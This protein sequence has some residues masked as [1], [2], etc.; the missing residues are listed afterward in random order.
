[1]IFKTR[2]FFFTTLIVIFILS[3]STPVNSFKPIFSKG[4]QLKCREEGQ[5]VVI[6]FLK[7]DPCITCLCQ[8]STI[9]CFKDACPQGHNCYYQQTNSSSYCCS[10]CK[11]CSFNGKYLANGETAQD[12]GDL[13]LSYQCNSGVM[14]T[15]RSQCF[16]PCSNAVSLRGQCC[17][18][19][20][21]CPWWNAK[22]GQEVVTAAAKKDP[23]IRCHCFKGQLICMRQVCPVLPCP[24]SNWMQPLHSCCPVCKG[25]KDAQKLLLP[26][27][28]S[29]L[30]ADKTYRHEDAFQY[31]ECT[32]CVCQNGTSICHRQTCSCPLEE[33]GKQKT[34]TAD[35]GQQCCESCA[36]ASS[37]SIVK[38]MQTSTISNCHYKS[39]VYKESQQWTN[40]DTCEHCTCLGGKV[41]CSSLAAATARLC[42]HQPLICPPGYQR[43]KQKGQCCESCLMLG[44]SCHLRM[45]P[46]HPLQKSISTFDGVRFHFAGQ[47]NYVLMKDCSSKQF[48]VHLLNRYRRA[49]NGSNFEG[50]SVMVKI[51]STKIHLGHMGVVR[52]NHSKVTLPYIELGHFTIA[53]FDNR[54]KVRVS[55]ME[56]E[57]LF[58]FN[59]SVEIK[60]KNSHQGRLCGLCGNFNNNLDDE[61]QLKNTRRIATLEKFARSFQVG[62][63]LVCPKRRVFVVKSLPQKE[64]HHHHHH[65]QQQQHQKG[66]NSGEERPSAEAVAISRRICD[67]IRKR[68]PQCRRGHP[69]HQLSSS[70]GNSVAFEQCLTSMTACAG[71]QFCECRALEHFIGRCSGRWH[72]ALRGTMCTKSTAPTEVTINSCPPGSEWKACTSG[73]CRKT[74]RSGRSSSEQCHQQRRTAECRPGCQCIGNRVWHQQQCIPEVMCPADS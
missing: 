25:K 49:A 46:H 19:C 17:P 11:G 70:A 29:C 63:N 64:E 31:D 35:G 23:C 67:R 68:N 10:K 55:K 16:V 48:A 27:G 71:D 53:R 44:G 15:H 5:V 54:I 52:V 21:I 12:D 14:T 59:A 43:V 13:C 42:P 60:V 7:A 9:N 72:N 1:M 26:D 45:Q 56:F 3:S 6:P 73:G 39:K 61:F 24:K 65:R 51:E 2:N 28:G 41:H 62:Q 69:H 66:K 33:K 47:C 32:N 22:D 18:S 58:T 30:L 4:S 8:N 40:S 74:C 36:L 57:V 38:T 50:T 20:T 37:S 34:F